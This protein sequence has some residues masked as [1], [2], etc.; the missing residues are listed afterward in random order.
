MTHHFTAMQH[1]YAAGARP[2]LPF[3]RHGEKVNGALCSRSGGRILSWWDDK[4]L[5]L[6]DGETGAPISPL[7]FANLQKAGKLF[8]GRY[9]F[10]TSEV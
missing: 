3:M 8:Q 10:L 1:F 5:R 4:T 7:P 9:S 2:S 6:W